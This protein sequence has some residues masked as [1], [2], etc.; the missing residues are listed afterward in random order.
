MLTTGGVLSWYTKSDRYSR[1]K[2]NAD[3]ETLRSYYLQRG[4]MEF[5]IDSTQVAISPDKKDISIT[6]NVTEGPRLVVSGVA[7]DGN[8]LVG[9]PANAYALQPI[10]VQGQTGL[11][12]AA[13]LES[14]QGVLTSLAD[15]YSGFLQFG[16]NDFHQLGSAF[17]G[18]GWQRQ[19]NHAAING[20]VSD[21]R[22]L[23][24]A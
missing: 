19:A 17:L 24:N 12:V 11:N 14:L 6:I 2:L 8:F 21:V 15:G 22:T 1:V 4:Y 5:R 23:L 16:V 7:L 20:R 10:S 9:G 3:L 18:E 13:G